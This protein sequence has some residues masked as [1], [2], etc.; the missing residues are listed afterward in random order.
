MPRS[1][2]RAS[3]RRRRVINRRFNLVYSATRAVGYTRR[4]GGSN[5]TREGSASAGRNHPIQN[6]SG[7]QP[8]NAVCRPSMRPGVADQYACIVRHSLYGRGAGWHRAVIVKSAARDAQSCPRT[9]ERPSASTGVI[10]ESASASSFVELPITSI[11]R[12]LPSSQ[13]TARISGQG[14]HSAT[15][16]SPHADS[17]RFN[18]RTPTVHDTA[19]TKHTTSTRCRRWSIPARSRFGRPQVSP[20][21]VTL[22]SLI[23]HAMRSR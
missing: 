21:T 8:R 7:R 17:E 2:R 6:A 19:R 5:L 9:P 14:R 18:I 23:S 13:R 16:V 3:H 1:C 10:I 4:P 15:H 22:A 11:Q 12:S 20:S